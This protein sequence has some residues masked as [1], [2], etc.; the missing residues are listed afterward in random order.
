MAMSCLKSPYVEVHPHRRH[1]CEVPS[2]VE[3]PRSEMGRS[4]P[5]RQAFVPRERKETVFQGK[6]RNVGWSRT[7]SNTEYLTRRSANF[8]NAHKSRRC[9]PFFSPSNFRRFPPDVR[10][11]MTSLPTPLL[12]SYSTA[13]LVTSLKNLLTE[14]IRLSYS[15]G[16]CP[17][18]PP[19]PVPASIEPAAAAVSTAAAFDG[20]E[21]SRAEYFAAV[22]GIF[23]PEAGPLSDNDKLRERRRR[24]RKKLKEEAAAAAAA[25]AAAGNVVDRGD[26]EQA[27]GTGTNSG[28]GNSGSGHGEPKPSPG[29]ASVHD[30]SP[31]AGEGGGGGGGKEGRGV[32]EGKRGDGGSDDGENGTCRSRRSDQAQAEGATAVAPAAEEAS[33]T[34]V[35]DAVAAREQQPEGAGDAAAAAD[36]PAALADGEKQKLSRRSRSVPEEE[37][38]GAEEGA[39]AARRWETPAEARARLRLR[40]KVAWDGVDVA[41]AGAAVTSAIMAK[42]GSRRSEGW[43]VAADKASRLSGVLSLHGRALSREDEEA[44]GRPGV[45][46]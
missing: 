18:V 31:Q 9:C 22:R 44:G 45:T 17:Y 37:K 39:A 13:D 41:T 10:R 35:D 6:K 38:E 42:S 24:R 30:K 32:E 1:D 5:S 29:C 27:S 19:R 2:E 3:N 36:P 40:L 7:A 11:I 23:G 4:N 20:D 26:R 21:P 25:A 8:V 14:L 16:D 12:L 33:A 46:W 34:S 43:A 28:G 15:M